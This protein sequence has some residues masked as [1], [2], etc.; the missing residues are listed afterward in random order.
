MNRGLL[1]V[2]EIHPH[3]IWEIFY[4]DNKLYGQRMNDAISETFD[5][6]Q[7]LSKEL[8]RSLNEDP[9]SVGEAMEKMISNAKKSTSDS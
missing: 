7:R 9:G 4:Y 1:T 6:A 8:I 3:D 5:P 2:S